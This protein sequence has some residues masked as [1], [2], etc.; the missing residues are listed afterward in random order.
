MKG[1]STPGAW[2]VLPFLLAALAFAAQV[3][4]PGAAIA[5][6]L[7]YFLLGTMHGAGDEQDG[8]LRRFDLWSAAAYVAAGLAVAALFVAQP[9]AGLTLFLALSLWHF[10]RSLNGPALRGFAFAAL[11]TGGSM[12]FR[13]Q[14]TAA[15]FAL[16]TAAP[17]PTAWLTVWAVIGALGVAVAAVQLLRQPADAVLWLTLPAMAFLHPVLAV[18]TAFLVGHALPVQRD[19][20]RRYGFRTI[21]AAQGPTTLLAL[22]GA[23]VL[24]ALWVNDVLPIGLVAALAFG[25]AT[26]HMLADRLER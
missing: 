25:F 5:L 4:G 16:I 19:Q 2:A 20:G 13:Y 7:V 17:L 10:A 15:I 18:G 21:L 3:A 14:E 26:P 9:L 1:R 6:G 24:A 23:A 8:T 22:G 12:L 11:A